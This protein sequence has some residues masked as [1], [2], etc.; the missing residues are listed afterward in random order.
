[1][2]RFF[3]EDGYRIQSKDLIGG[4]S[5]MT[6]LSLIKSFWNKKCN[7]QLSKCRSVTGNQNIRVHYFD[8]RQL[9]LLHQT[10]AHNYSENAYHPLDI[11]LK[12]F[13]HQKDHTKEEKFNSV[14]HPKDKRVFMKN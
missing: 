14:F 4:S 5:T 6:T 13:F 12:T 9:L 11:D 10:N 3:I 1:M 7:L 8:N 2:Y